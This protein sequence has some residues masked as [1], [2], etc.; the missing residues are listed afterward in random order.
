MN[1]KEIKSKEKVPV[2]VVITNYNGERT[3]VD[4]IGSLLRLQGVDPN[5][6]VIDDG[7][8]DN[9]IADA[10]NAFADLTVIRKGRNTKAIN[11]LRNEGVSHT[12][13]E[14]VF[15]I[16]NDVT[17]EADC[18]HE[19]LNV[20]KSDDKIAVCIPILMNWHD[21]ERI[22]VAGGK[23]H[24][25]GASISPNRG[26]KLEDVGI[27]TG[28]GMG[29]GIALFRK[30]VFDQLGGFDENY[31]LAWGDDGEL[32]QRM[33]A[34]GH[35]AYLVASAIGYH[36]EKPFSSERYYRAIGQLHNRFYFIATY[37]DIRTLVILFPA[38]LLYEFVQFTF[39]AVKRMPMQYFS[40]YK[41]AIESFPKTL[42]KRKE[43]QQLKTVSDRELLF[44]GPLLVAKSTLGKLDIL[45]GA[46]TALS[47]FYVGYW[48]IA[49]HLI[50]ARIKK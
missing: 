23:F 20:M 19:L 16:D 8:T 2:S 7:S 48:A 41:L 18:L 5:I 11:S 31:M 9:S 42:K 30:A 50:K 29:G 13:T 14:F 22:Y 24:Y 43:I 17:F 21:R 6:V 1:V 46:I 34:A 32:H 45:G 33:V 38:L 39:F 49:R 12:K 3:L 15:V 10:E 4:T 44:S 36:E 35:K 47:Y 28:F 37:Y 26:E 25:I 40:G 27:E